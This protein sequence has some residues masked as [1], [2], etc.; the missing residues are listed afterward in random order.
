MSGSKPR[1]TPQQAIELREAA[2]T[3]V[4]CKDLALRYGIGRTAVRNY[5][6][7]QIQA[8]EIVAVSPRPVYLAAGRRPKLTN[9]QA[10]LMR[11]MSG[12]GIK[13]TELGRR[14][15]LSPSGVKRYLKFSQK[16]RLL[17]A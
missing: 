2:K 3:G 16:S 12:Q 5:L 1:L 9:E 11:S 14:F 6:R 10:V 13:P 17:A 15:G 4:T 8:P 7:G